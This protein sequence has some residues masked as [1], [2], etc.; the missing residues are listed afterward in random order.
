MLNGSGTGTR[1]AQNPP[2]PENTS[3]PVVSGSALQD[4]VLS[5]STGSWSNTPTSY[6]YQWQ[7]SNAQGTFDNISGATSS[8]YTV[9]ASDVSFYLRVAVRATNESGTSLASALSTQTA[10]VVAASSLGSSLPARLPFSS[11]AA[12]YYVN[13]STGNDT[14]GNGSSGTPWATINKAI[15]SVSTP[16]SIIH[17]SDGTYTISAAG[18]SNAPIYI[19]NKNH[20]GTTTNPITI[21]AVNEGGVVIT[22]PTDDLGYF[23]GCS[24]DNSS[25]Y[26]IQGIKFYRIYG[27]GGSDHPGAD[28]AFIYRS[29]WIEFYRCQFVDIGGQ[30][31]VRGTLNDPCTDIG[32]WC[33][34]H[35]PSGGVNVNYNG[36]GNDTEYCAGVTCTGNYFTT[37]GTHC[38]YPGQVESGDYV[39]KYGV[40]R[41]VIANNLFVGKTPGCHVDLHPQARNCYV[42]NNTFYGNNKS[43]FTLPGQNSGW[44]AGN[45]IILGND[46]TLNPNT[47]SNCVVKNN[48]FASMIGHAVRTDGAGSM[49]GNVVDYN[50]AYQTQNGQGLQGNSTRPFEYHWSTGSVNFTSPGGNTINTDPKFVSPSISSGAN[51]ALQGSSPALGVGDPA[52]AP[53][54]DFSGAARSNPPSLGAIG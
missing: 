14:T 29:Q 4:Q 36:L 24:I 40:D 17:V 47:T 28:A 21:K 42:V 2:L 43:Y 5:A 26:R 6:L 25:G 19:L 52:Y 10:A 9:T 20:A 51:F 34:H 49:V 48:I 15:N 32:W 8:S 46:G 7:R 39:N 12:N 41:M 16:G 23:Y 38:V 37:R 27:H 31:Q 54:T 11:G 53:A 45:G 22:H 1:P 33:N 50:L 44:S 3:L 18:D 30:V 13:P 35:Y